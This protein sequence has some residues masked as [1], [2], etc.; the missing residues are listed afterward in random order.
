MRKYLIL[1]LLISAISLYSCKKFLDP[2]SDNIY[3]DEQLLN[4]PVYAEGLLMKAYASLP[5][6]YDFAT[7][8]ASDDAISNDQTSLYKL[9]ALGGWKSTND[10]ISKWAYANEQIFY[11]NKFLSSYDKVVWSTDPNLTQA[12]KDFRNKLHKKRLKG[13]AYSLRAWYK[14][15]LLQYHGGL[16]DGGTLLGFPI[17]DNYL[18]ATDN[19][20]LPR[21]TFAQ[22]VTSI[23][24]D[25]DTAKANLPL[26]WFDRAT[27]LPTNLPTNTGNPV[28]DQA[29]DAINK[30][31]A[32]INQACADTNATS[33]A[34]F[35]N[36]INGNISIA[37]KARVALLA[38][39]P[40]FSATSGVTW[41]QAATIAG[42]LLKSLGA[43]SATGRVF[44]KN[45][46]DPDI[47]WNRSE[48]QKRNWEQ[49]NFP[50]LLFGYGRTNPTQNLVD[51]FGMK[52]GFPITN[53]AQ[54]L[55]NP[56]DPYYNRDPRLADYIVY[57][58]AVLKSPTIIYT[59]VGA[60]SNGINVLLTST[61]TGYYLKKFMN[62]SVKLDPGSQV[63]AGHTYTL[64][65]QTELL[66]NYAEA[67]NEA[68]GPTGDPN[69]Y[70]FTAKSLIGDVR[71]RGGITQPDAYLATI[72]DA[73][74]LRD[75]IKNE[76]RIELCFEGFRFWDIRR[77]NDLTTMQASAKAAYITNTS[78]V[79]SYVY[80]NVE[81]R[82]YTA[83]MIYGPVPYSE[84]VKYNLDQN[85]GW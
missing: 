7:D 13:E 31:N 45:K 43:L 8:I 28:T 64:F 72:T 39:S 56:A 57:N 75:L 83:N 74:G 34:R 50:P 19:W 27:N 81:E 17:I 47:L 70:G 62:E 61:R 44:Y 20:K 4:N 35:L 14:W 18:T 26:K 58:A 48:V 85:K 55:Y 33:G 73:N 84:I 49:D 40:A 29:N 66:L 53:L 22:C 24:N 80:N 78:G 67:A 15:M 32:K 36:R 52:N 54:S 51:A 30:A 2:K 37:L 71:K 16:T 69:G 65:R 12:T 41:A 46:I 77:W 60:P 76:R 38:S 63:S 1:F 11:I 79:Y 6:E 68:W 59:Y 23:F 9:M 82:K 3:T 21:N 42:P 25:L 10:P 5:N